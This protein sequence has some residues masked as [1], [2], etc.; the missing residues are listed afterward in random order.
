MGA[1]GRL[2]AL[3]ESE[4]RVEGETF[5]VLDEPTGQVL[6]QLCSVFVLD[7]YVHVMQPARL[8]AL[9]MTDG[10]ETA[11]W[12][13]PRPTELGF[14]RPGFLTPLDR[15]DADTFLW[16]YEY[17]AEWASPPVAC[18]GASGETRSYGGVELLT[19]N[20]ATD[21]WRR[22]RGPAPLS[23]VPQRLA[24]DG[25]RP[26]FYLLDEVGPDSACIWIETPF[27]IDMARATWGL[28]TPSGTTVP[29]AGRFLAQG[30][31]DRGCSLDVLV[32]I[33][34]PYT[35]LLLEDDVLADERLS[36]RLALRRKPLGDIRAVAGD[37]RG[38]AFEVAAERI[39]VAYWASPVIRTRPRF[40]DDD[41]VVPGAGV[42]PHAADPASAREIEV[43]PSRPLLRF[44]RQ[45]VSRLD[46]RGRV[47]ESL[48]WSEISTLEEGPIGGSDVGSAGRVLSVARGGHRVEL[49]ATLTRP[50]SGAEKRRCYPMHV[51][52]HDYERAR[53]TICEARG[54][55]ASTKRPATWIRAA[56]AGAVPPLEEV[57]L[58][59]VYT[60]PR[61]TV[62][63]SA[64]GLESRRFPLSP[65][66]V[67]V[68]LVA[69]VFVW[70]AF[71]SGVG[72]G[73]SGHDRPAQAEPAPAGRDPNAR[74]SPSAIGRVTMDGLALGMSRA[75]AE[76]R[77]AAL[78]GE[79]PTV[80]C[81]SSGTVVVLEGKEARSDS[82]KI[83]RAGDSEAAAMAFLGPERRREAGDLPTWSAPISGGRMQVTLLGGRVFGLS[84]AG[85]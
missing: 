80:R 21:S 71:M 18:V 55:V 2:L 85:R 58:T 44:D 6:R 15:L 27:A 41:A 64:S 26:F 4:V 25:E 83:L 79:R 29:A 61:L 81:G 37:G 78:T 43:G 20:R 40:Q 33:E 17:V 75:S 5:H 59:T 13:M 46:G 50:L 82:G 84:L 30:G 49:C 73:P 1:D 32:G 8:T 57:A 67:L 63:E 23:E 56:G 7:P 42:E 16:A 66:A 28:E 62:A 31:V 53:R 39:H 74:V 24:W 70:A 14:T 48:A 52:E 51:A 60:A 11:R 34:L 54:L 10:R 35:H 38:V 19:W 3:W 77:L 65:Y 9:D 47:V 22:L 68:L 72:P 36:A 12:A 69:G 76:S 45:G